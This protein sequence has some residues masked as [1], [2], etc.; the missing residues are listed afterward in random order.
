MIEYEPVKAKNN[1]LLLPR[2]A[3]QEIDM[4]RIAVAELQPEHRSL[5][6]FAVLAFSSRDRLDVVIDALLEAEQRGLFSTDGVACD[7]ACKL[8][9]LRDDL[10]L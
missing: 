10:T 2:L 1:L 9:S 5:V 4:M 3:P 8:M 6:D 7:L